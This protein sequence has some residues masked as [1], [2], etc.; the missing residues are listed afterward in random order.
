M[1]TTVAPAFDRED[2]EPADRDELISRYPDCADMI[3]DLTAGN[4][5]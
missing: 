2:Y 4:R 5:E 3:L 1:G